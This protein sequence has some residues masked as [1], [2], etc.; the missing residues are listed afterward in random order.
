MK[1]HILTIGIALLFIIMLGTIV[2]LYMAQPDADPIN[3]L[4]LQ[5][6]P[7]TKPPY[8]AKVFDLTNWKL[9]LPIGFLKHPTEV[10]QPELATYGIDPWFMVNKEGNGIRFRAPVNGVT[11]SGSSYPRSE[12]REMVKDGKEKA[13]WSSTLGI[14]TMTLEE[15]I[16]AVP[17]HKRHVVAGQIHD[18]SDDVLVIRL[19]YPKLYVNVDGDNVYTLDSNYTLGKKF[20]IKMAVMGEETKI[21]YNNNPDPIYTLSKKYSGAY[22]KAGAYTQSNCTREISPDLCNADNYG[23]VVVYNVTITHE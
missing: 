16:T 12:L 7:S 5:S 19:E 8:P 4:T 15:A 23:E 2:V 1:P 18:D 11:T 10:K 17:K 21:Y 14:H 6:K 3:S 9:T 22:F 13:N 20:T